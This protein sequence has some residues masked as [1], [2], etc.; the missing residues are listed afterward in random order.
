[1]L[2]QLFSFIIM[3]V[4]IWQ[5]VYDIGFR[6]SNMVRTGHMK[7]DLPKGFKIGAVS[8]LPWA[9]FFI[10]SVMLNIKFSVYRIIN[11]L[12]WSFLTLICGVFDG[13]RLAQLTMQDLSVLKL[14]GIALLFFIIPIISGSVY[15][16][17]YKGIDIFSLIIYKKRKGK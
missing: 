2:S 11:S 17:G 12:Y 3:V 10:V 15:I 4:L 13:K 8:Q 16:L 1:M 5:T 7:E 14:G 6:D 9:V